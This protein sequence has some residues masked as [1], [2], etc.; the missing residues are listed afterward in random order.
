MRLHNNMPIFL[1]QSMI[2]LKIP[3]LFLE[4]K[5]CIEIEGLVTEL[6]MVDLC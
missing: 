1:L 2:K 3:A 5:F 4:L 6:D